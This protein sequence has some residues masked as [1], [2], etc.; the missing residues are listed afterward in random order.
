MSGVRLFAI[1]DIPVWVSPWYLLVLLFWFSAGDF[2]GNMVWAVCVTVSILVHE[3]GHA[4][5]ARHFGLRPQILLHGLGGLCAHD[6]AKKDGHDAL[7]IAAGPTAGLLLGGLTF[8]VAYFASDA[9]TDLEHARLAQLVVQDMLYINILWSFIN[10]LPMWPL[11]GGQLYR[12]GMMRLASPRR[13]EKITHVTA[14]LVCAAGAYFAYTRYPS[15]FVV[16]M[17]GLLAYYNYQALTG[18]VSSGIVRLESKHAKALLVDAEK[19]FAAGDYREAARLGHLI[20]DEKN[21]G[22]TVLRRTWEILGVSAAHLGQH[23]DALRFLDRA[24]ATAAT[25][26]ARIEC[27]YKLHRDDELHALLE[28]P[29]F[30]KVRPDRRREILEVL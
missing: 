10:L 21:V 11:D 3:L 8:A 18:H 16:I 29:D 30:Q 4:L 27:L 17:C 19:A 2:T 23:E 20:R 7:I 1:G 22:D 25:V 14:I 28:S 6:R 24:P 5:V 13:A 26:E 9:I 15:M 12:L